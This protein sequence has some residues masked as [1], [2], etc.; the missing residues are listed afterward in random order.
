MTAFFK[1]RNEDR[2]VFTV[3][4][5]VANVRKRK[6]SKPGVV[7]RIYNP[8]TWEVAAGGL[9]IPGQPGLHSEFKSSLSYIARLFQKTKN[10]LDIVVHTYNPNSLGDRDWM[11]CSSRPTQA[12]C[13]RDSIST[14]NKP[15]CGGARLSSSYGVSISKRI[16]VQASLS[17]QKITKAKRTGA[18]FKYR[19]PA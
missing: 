15:R 2:T 18:W 8:S 19:V 14:Y 1:L 11:D 4:F 5:L 17:I 12:K 9:R 16:V 13:S 7:V 3:N 6:R 10:W